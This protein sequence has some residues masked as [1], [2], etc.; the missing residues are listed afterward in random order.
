MKNTITITLPCRVCEQDTLEATVYLN[1]R[2]V[3]VTV[4]DT[5]Y[6]GGRDRAIVDLSY[7][8]VKALYSFLDLALTEM[9]IAESEIAESE[10]ADEELGEAD[11]FA[12][13]FEEGRSQGF[14]EGYYAGYDEGLSKGYDEGLRNGYEAE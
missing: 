10:I 14:D 8:S 1:S 13:G 2:V 6:E 7:E 4:E 12:E 11:S 3:S 5:T 9:E